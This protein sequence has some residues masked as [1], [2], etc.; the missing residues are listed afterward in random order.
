MSKD[1]DLDASAPKRKR[2][3]KADA[4]TGA[5]QSKGKSLQSHGRNSVVYVPVILKLFKDRWRPG[6]STVVF[7][8]DD[9]RTAVEAVRA[10]SP[11]PDRI[12]SRNPADVVYRM[13]SRTVLPKEI[14]DKG[15]HVLRA[16]G[17]G[18]YQFEKASSGII[19]TPVNEITPAIDQTPMPVRRLLPET[20]AEMDEQA[21][22][23]VVGYCNLFDHFSGM[24][25]Y[26]LR[27]HIKYSHTVTVSFIQLLHCC[28]HI[29]QALTSLR[30]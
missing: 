2:A 9:V 24:K 15:F 8:L 22:L 23:S 25:I 12:S 20:M 27:S 14:L 29:D 1:D 19:D 26:R 21:L 17:R 10:I 13:R 3:T 11:N 16:V 30:L 7:S 28:V 18:R 4:V 5:A 6:A